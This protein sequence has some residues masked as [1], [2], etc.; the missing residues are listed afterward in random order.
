MGAEIFDVTLDFD[1]VLIAN[2]EKADY[3]WDIESSSKKT[4]DG[5]V[6]FGGNDPNGNAGTISIDTI[7]WPSEL[8]D[9]IA[10]ENKLRSNDLK[11]IKCIA[12]G[13]TSKGDKYKRVIHGE[14]PTLSKNSEGWTPTD[15]ISKSLELNCRKLEVDTQKA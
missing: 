6:N 9:A 11:Y 4:F 14:Y 1:G 2:A 13:Y 3:E 10:L 5:P 7:Y 15:G 12:Y 8:D